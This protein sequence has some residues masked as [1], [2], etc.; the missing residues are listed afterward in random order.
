MH[1]EIAL[2]GGRALLEKG[3]LEEAVTALRRAYELHPTSL[4]IASDLAKAMLRAERVD[5]AR[6]HLDVAIARLPGGDLLRLQR[7]NLHL[8]TG[9]HAAALA[10]FQQLMRLAPELPD[11]RVGTILALVG[12]GRGDDAT[13]ELAVLSEQGVPAELIAELRAVIEQT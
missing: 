12:L 13:V 2:A 5:E 1:A 4:E 9:D 3:S 6:A 7:G 11:A 8:G 10:D